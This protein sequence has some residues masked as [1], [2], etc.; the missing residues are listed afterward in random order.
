[1]PVKCSKCH[2]ENTA[3]SQFCK[4]CAA[5]FP[6]SD[7]V[8]IS[9]TRTLETPKEKLTRGTTF[10]G[11]YEIIEELGRGGMGIVY[12]AE[13]TKLKRTVALKFIA[14][15]S[16]ASDEMKMRF[17]REAQSA[18]SL[19]HPNITIIYEIDEIEGETFITMEYIEGQTLKKKIKSSPLKVG[20]ALDIVFQIAEGLQEAH[21]K[22][23]IH[24]DIK[25]SNIMLRDKGQV[26]IMDFGLAKIPGIT[27][28]TKPDTVIGTVAFMSPEQARGEPLDCRTDIWSLGVTLFEMLIGRH[29]FEG[30]DDQTV[31]Y[32]I[33][34]KRPESITSLRSGMPLELERIVSKC[35]EKDPTERYQTIADLKADLKHLNR[36]MSTGEA[37]IPHTTAS[38]SLSLPKLRRKTI[39]PLGGVIL[40]LI[41]LLSVPISR[42]AVKKWLGFKTRPTEI[43]LAVLP[44]NIGGGGQ[45]EQVFGDGLVETLTSKLTQLEQIQ[46]SLWIVPAEKVRES[47]ITNPSEA[48]RSLGINLVVT[49]SMTHI[50]DGIIRLML[51]LLDAETLHPLKSPQVFTDPI[52]NL[53]TW[54]DD[55]FI[56]LVQMLD[57]ELTPQNRFT[58]TGEGTALPDAFEFYIKGLGF[59]QHLEKEGNLDTAIRLLKGTTEKDPH[60]A[61][62]YAELGK[63]YWYKYKLTQ[64][65]K[66][67][68]EAVTNCERAIELSESLVS[69]HITLGIIYRSTGK[70]EDGLKEFQKALKLE[71]KN[72]DVHLEL[73][74]AYEEDKRLPEAE[75]KYREAIK[76][77]PDYWDGFNNL[78]VFCLNQDNFTDAEKMFRKVIELAPGNI[79]G[80]NNLGVSQYWSSQ[81]E[82]A[83]A[84]F[85]KSIDI[86][87]NADAC[88]NLGT[89]YF[90]QGRYADAM[91]MFEAAIELGL[92][93]DCIIWE[94]LAD[95]Y[96]YMPE[97]S[98]KAPGAYQ[99]AFELAKKE[100]EISPDDAHLRSIL[101]YYHTVSGD[102]KKALD[103][104]SKALELA[105]KD[106]EV[107]LQ[108]ITVYELSNE[109]DQALQALKKYVESGSAM[110][111]VRVNPDLKG[112]RMDPRYKQF[113]KQ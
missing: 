97:F 24:R 22:G 34:N 79:R 1:M 76:L 45:E 9:H 85:E 10:A 92:T 31:L 104:I 6:S 84:T 69:P 5:P 11:R 57:I 13:D 105:P 39:L 81:E 36:H 58:L 110:N 20:E 87:R 107:L 29:P 101:A 16:L 88:S 108:S 27:K 91:S 18:A 77:K 40:M 41:V 66:F 47:K 100:L 55:V 59:M 7:D 53:F 21:E 109:R 26:K 73:A 67:V 112:L 83:A 93:D 35:L 3:D 63:A 17:V 75:E 62:A 94:N 61:L 15:H 32:A 89:I 113:I 65:L 86:E 49:G 38:V 4:S 37:F 98:D 42:R 50:G 25:C 28:I 54:Q 12:K 52:T 44:F 68:E 102:Q 43:G 19:N 74:M 51:N 99:K 23:I 78:G 82:L 111:K 106:V 8:S 70:Y 103:E 60:Y 72:Y 80:Y 46:R 2:T 96:R 90:Y 56:K 95:T 30:E 48:G 71:P 33:H 14:P 64:D